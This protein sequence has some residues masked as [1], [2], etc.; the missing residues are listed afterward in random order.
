MDGFYCPVTRDTVKAKQKAL[1]LYVDGIAGLI[2]LRALG[3]IAGSSLPKP[4]C[5][6]SP[7]WL[8]DNDLKQNTIILLCM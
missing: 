7:R 5:M 4:A 1:G 3:L 2:T 8:E 6:T